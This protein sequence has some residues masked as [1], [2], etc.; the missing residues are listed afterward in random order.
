MCNDMMETTGEAAEK[1]LKNLA[2]G[3]EEDDDIVD[4]WT[5]SSKS[6]TGVDYDKLV[7]NNNVFSP[8]SLP[9]I[10]RFFFST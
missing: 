9:A 7:G 3:D 6:Q 10:C 8:K 4:P 1:G 2:M 5:V